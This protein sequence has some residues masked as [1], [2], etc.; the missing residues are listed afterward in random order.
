MEKQITKEPW[1][2]TREEFE[3]FAKGTVIYWSYPYQEK[4]S[5]SLLDTFPYFCYTTDYDKASC[6]GRAQKLG[7]IIENVLLPKVKLWNEATMG[8]FS[9]KYGKLEGRGIPK[10]LV[11]GYAGIVKPG[12]E[13]YIIFP[14][15]KFTW[16]I[17]GTVRR[18][19]IKQALSEG[20]SVPAERIAEYPELMPMRGHLRR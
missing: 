5:G 20:K 10:A 6:G 2:M 15:A 1:E 14:E 13:E 12:G 3:Q 18:E 16:P 9:A 19:F 17:W 8:P 7:Y 4:F 11:D